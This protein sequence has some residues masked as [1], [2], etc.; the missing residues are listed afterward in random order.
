MTENIDITLADD[1]LLTRSQVCERLKITP[2]TLYLWHRAGTAPPC[3]RI[4]RSIRYPAR[5]FDEY[6]RSR[7]QA[8]TVAEHDHD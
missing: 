7:V 4:G 8:D 6:L 5:L 1:E 3:V 2:K